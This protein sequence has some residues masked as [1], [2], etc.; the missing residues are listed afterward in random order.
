MSLFSDFVFIVILSLVNKKVLEGKI[1]KKPTTIL[2][3][4]KSKIKIF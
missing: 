3:E 4:I 1:N 2:Q